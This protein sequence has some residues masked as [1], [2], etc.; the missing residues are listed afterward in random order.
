MGNFLAGPDIQTTKDN[1]IANFHPHLATIS[2]EIV[3][4][5]KD[6]ASVVGEKQVLGAV[7]KASKIIETL[8]GK[9]FVFVLELAADTWKDLT[10]DE[11]IALL[12]HLLHYCGGEEK[13]EDG[14]MRWFID[15]PD[16]MYF[17]GE[18]ER[19]GFWK[20]SGFKAP[21]HEIDNLFGKKD[22]ESG[23]A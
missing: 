17:R 14:S 5:F 19:H 23:L 1:L 2:D 3:V 20:T 15:R 16:V 8:T 21:A 7:K 10:D 22:A 6:K 11:R 13:E 4:I 9:T 18:V 12:D